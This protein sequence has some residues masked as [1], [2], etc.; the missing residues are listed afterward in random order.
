MLSLSMPKSMDYGAESP[1]ARRLR[2][3]THWTPVMV[4][5]L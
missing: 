2:R 1:E 3:E 5:S 4:E